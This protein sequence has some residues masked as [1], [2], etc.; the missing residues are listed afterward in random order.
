MNIS[1]GRFRSSSVI[2]HEQCP[3]SDSYLHRPNGTHTYDLARVGKRFMMLKH[4]AD[5]SRLIV[6]TNWLEKLRAKP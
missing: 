2:V 4:S 1:Y 3:T 6:V 5:Q